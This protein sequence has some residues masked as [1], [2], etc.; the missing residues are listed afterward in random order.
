MYTDI[1]TTRSSRGIR[2][3]E[4][5]E[6]FKM[7]RLLSLGVL[8]LVLGL[9]VAAPVSEVDMDSEEMAEFLDELVLR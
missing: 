7:L 6:V 4:F 2:V 3:S 8:G 5:S 9:A 1:Y